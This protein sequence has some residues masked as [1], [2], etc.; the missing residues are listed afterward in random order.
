MND[1]KG[2]TACRQL[3]NDDT[4]EVAVWQL[5]CIPSPWQSGDVTAREMSC[6]FEQHIDCNHAIL[7][8]YGG[9][10]RILVQ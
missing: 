4:E 5:C 9:R 10:K 8:P 2:V 6:A 3:D 1:L 7:Q